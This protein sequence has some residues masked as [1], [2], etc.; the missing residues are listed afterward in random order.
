MQNNI[1]IYEHLSADSNFKA[2]CNYYEMADYVVDADLTLHTVEPEQWIN[3]KYTGTM[4]ELDMYIQNIK[5]KL[6]IK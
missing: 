1:T 5:M 6:W 2:T 4:E 3:E